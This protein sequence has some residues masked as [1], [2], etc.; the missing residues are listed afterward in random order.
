MNYGLQRLQELPLCVRLIKEIHNA[1]LHDVRGREKNPG[2]VRSSQNW[3]GPG[4][5]TLHTA[6]FVPPSPHEV[7]SALGDLETFMHSDTSFQRS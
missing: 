3:I 6:S 4:G 7:M 1:L 2:E 5:C